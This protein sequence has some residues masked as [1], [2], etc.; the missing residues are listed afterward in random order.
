[1]IKCISTAIMNTLEKSEKRKKENLSKE[2]ESLRKE[3]EA[4]KEETNELKSTK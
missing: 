1:M 3:I 2:I 4:C